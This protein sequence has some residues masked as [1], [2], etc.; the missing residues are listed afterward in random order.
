MGPHQQKQRATAV[1]NV[2]LVGISV[3][4][5]KNPPTWTQVGDSFRIKRL[6]RFPATSFASLPFLTIGLFPSWN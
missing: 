4:P 3:L 6:D 5:E 1:N 2:P